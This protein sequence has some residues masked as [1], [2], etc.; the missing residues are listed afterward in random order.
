MESAIKVNSRVTER[1]LSSGAYINHRDNV[2]FSLYK[3]HLF[4]S[5]HI[6]FRLVWLDRII[7]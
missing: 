5:N 6:L 1:L 7:S 3:L 2:R 4:E